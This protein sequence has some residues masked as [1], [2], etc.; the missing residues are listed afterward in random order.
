ME[1]GVKRADLNS[2]Y[3]SFRISSNISTMRVIA[4]LWRFSENDMGLGRHRT[5]AGSGA[6]SISDLVYNPIRDQTEPFVYGGAG[7]FY[8]KTL[9]VNYRNKVK[10]GH[11]T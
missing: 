6:G 5:V 8:K 9:C 10:V 11:P 1:H 2:T 7:G 4:S 3:W